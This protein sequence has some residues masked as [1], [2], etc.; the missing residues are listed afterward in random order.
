MPPRT[1]SAQELSDRAHIHDLLTRYTIAIDTRDWKLL[2]SCFTPDAFV[3]YTSSG[4]IRGKYPEARAWLEKALAPFAAMQHFIG[5]IQLT[6]DGDRASSCTYLIN[7]M[8][9]PNED[10]SLHFFTVGAQY[11]DQLVHTDDGW[12]IAE[13]IEEQLYLQGSLPEALQ[14]PT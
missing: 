2:D 8:G 3:D 14:I 5:N 9:F 4:G 11:K 10:G 1:L 13:R 12:R 6:I 7:P